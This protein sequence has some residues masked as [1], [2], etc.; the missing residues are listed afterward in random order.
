MLSKS[1]LD[2]RVGHRG[3]NQLR[4]AV[5]A[6]EG[7]TLLNGGD[8]DPTFGNGGKV[9]TDLGPLGFA[10]G[11]ALQLDGKVVAA[12][13]SGGK[14]A[15]VRYLPDGSLDS[16]FGSGGVVTTAIGSGAAGASRVAV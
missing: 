11:V 15:L 10:T 14:F 16:G 5:E 12:G 7:R 2:P 9:V 1:A 8:L 4:P 13:S 6:L 3:K